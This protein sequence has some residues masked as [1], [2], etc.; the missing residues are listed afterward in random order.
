MFRPFMNFVSI[1]LWEDLVEYDLG[2]ISF[3]QVFGAVAGELSHS[4]E[5]T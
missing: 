2:K 3:Y 5:S 1:S 4:F